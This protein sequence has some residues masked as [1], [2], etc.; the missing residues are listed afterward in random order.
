MEGDL[1][2]E[3]LIWTILLECHSGLNHHVLLTESVSYS[4]MIC[5]RKE[6]KVSIIGIEGHFSFDERTL[7]LS[8]PL[9]PYIWRSPGSCSSYLERVPKSSFLDLSLELPRLVVSPSGESRILNQRYSESGGLEYI[10]GVKVSRLS[11]PDHAEKSVY[12]SNTDLQ[13]TCLVVTS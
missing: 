6:W 8:L 3:D 9:V 10:H 5:R 7:H 13:W 2:W 4:T 12:D 1:S 11:I